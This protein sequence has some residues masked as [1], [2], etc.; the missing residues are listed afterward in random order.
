MVIGLACNNLHPL[1]HTATK[2]YKLP[3]EF[4]KGPMKSM[5]HTSKISTIKI[6]LRGIIFLLEILPSF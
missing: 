5:P 2:L 1:G 4:E 3:K 6:G